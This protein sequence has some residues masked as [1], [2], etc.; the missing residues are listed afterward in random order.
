MKNGFET[1]SGRRIR[2]NETA[3]RFT[4]QTAIGTDHALAKFGLDFRHGQTLPAG[5]FVRNGIGID[6]LNPERRKKICYRTLATAN[7]ASE[8]DNESQCAAVACTL[9]AA[10]FVLGNASNKA[11]RSASAC[12]SGP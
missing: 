3:H 2:K 10:I 5:Q 8:P 4:I 11:A 9:Q 6:D 12:A 7:P 1:T